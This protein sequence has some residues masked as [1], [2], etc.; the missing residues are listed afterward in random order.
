VGGIRVCLNFIATA[1]HH[2]VPVRY[3]WNG[4]GWGDGVAGM[5]A[6]SYRNGLGGNNKKQYK[7]DAMRWFGKR[8]DWDWMDGF[9]EGAQCCMVTYRVLQVWG[10]L[11]GHSARKLVVRS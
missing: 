9:S 10:N 6:V 7:Y 4:M 5:A 1:R 11:S 8:G 3:E 2:T